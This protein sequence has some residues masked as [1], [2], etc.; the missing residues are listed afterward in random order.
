MIVLRIDWRARDTPIA[1]MPEHTHLLGGLSSRITA[2]AARSPASGAARHAGSGE[3]IRHGSCWY[4]C[5]AGHHQASPEQDG[6]SRVNARDARAQ[7]HRASRPILRSA[8]RA[9]AC[10]TRARS[11]AQSH[12]AALSGDARRGTSSITAH[13]RMVLW[14]RRSR[15]T[16][17]AY[18]AHGR[19]APHEGRAVEAD[20]VGMVCP[21]LWA[22]RQRPSPDLRCSTQH[23]RGGAEEPHQT[24]RR[25]DRDEAQHET[26]S[27]EGDQHP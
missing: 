27:R 25:R 21:T 16:Q 9:R 3:R 20:D 1:T 12:R 18:R 10:A 22:A 6:R 19:G 11:S 24:R 7:A 14:W 13:F 5:A 26:R 2:S 15:K 23:V 8:Q 17:D 4:R